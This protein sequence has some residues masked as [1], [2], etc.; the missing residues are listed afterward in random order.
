MKIEIDIQDSKLQNLSSTAH[1]EIIKVSQTYLEDVLDEASRI[2][3]SR[4]TSVRA[5]EI[6]ASLINDAAHYARTFGIRKRKPKRLIFLQIVAFIGS[7]FTG[8]LFDVEKFK[9]LSYVLLFLLFFVI[10]VVSSVYLIFND[11]Q[12]D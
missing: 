8:G 3:E 5:P 2:E 11:N 4:R 9:S 1:S 7:I 6:T 12:N 10:A